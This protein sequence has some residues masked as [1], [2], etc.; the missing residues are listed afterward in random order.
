MPKA[1]VP[2]PSSLHQPHGKGSAVLLLSGRASTVGLCEEVDMVEGERL[3]LVSLLHDF[4]K[5][6]L[7]GILI[8]DVVLAAHQGSLF[9]L[10][11]NQF[12]RV[13]CGPFCL[14]GGP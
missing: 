14:S 1:Q 9:I 7:F 13:R 11:N 12:W 8:E 6:A 2:T 4:T 3:T 5:D 10:R